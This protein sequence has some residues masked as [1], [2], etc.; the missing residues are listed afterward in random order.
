VSARSLTVP[1]AR[2]KTLKRKDIMA[3]QEAMRWW[4]EDLESGEYPQTRGCLR[5]TEAAPN[6]DPAGYC[7]LGVACETAMK[8]GVE[9][10]VEFL[11]NGIVSYDGSTQLLPEKVAEFLGTTDDEMYNPELAYAQGL[12][13]TRAAYANDGFQNWSLARIAHA[14]RETY[15]GEA[16]APEEEGH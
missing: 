11:D 14:I 12:G 16:P 7:C 4:A 2:R 8:H 15:L 13:R 3:N 5:R 1:S 9:L 10:R 6:G